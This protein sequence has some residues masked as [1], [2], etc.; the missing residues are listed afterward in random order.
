MFRILQL[1]ALEALNRQLSRLMNAST[2]ESHLTSHV[3]VVAAV[4]D[5]VQEGTSAEMI[6]NCLFDLKENYGEDIETKALRYWLAIIIYRY[7]YGAKENITYDSLNKK[8]GIERTKLQRTSAENPVNCNYGVPN[9]RKNFKSTNAEEIVDSLCRAPNWPQ[10]TDDTYA[11][12]FWMSQTYLKLKGLDR[13]TRGLGQ[14]FGISATKVSRGSRNGL[15]PA[16]VG[17]QAAVD[18]H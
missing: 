15:T 8:F 1:R 14:R 16:D 7:D 10:M 11:L 3:D 12:R 6:L 17:Y 9:S 2:D 13:S 18:K 4:A 5:P